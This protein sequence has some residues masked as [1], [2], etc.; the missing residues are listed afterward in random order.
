M[1]KAVIGRSP[2]VGKAVALEKESAHAKTTFPLLTVR[3]A[4]KIAMAITA[5]RLASHPQHVLVMV[6]AVETALA[7]AW[8]ILRAK[9]ATLAAPTFLANIVKLHEVRQDHLMT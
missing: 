6:G 1:L 2:A 5:R 3:L 9:I 4:V 7:S 8:V